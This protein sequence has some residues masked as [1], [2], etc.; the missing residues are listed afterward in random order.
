MF[1]QLANK[2]QIIGANTNT[3]VFAVSQWDR[4][5]YPYALAHTGYISDSHREACYELIVDSNKNDHE[6]ANETVIEKAV[7]HNVDYVIPKDYVGR[8]YETHESFCNYLDLYRDTPECTAQTYAVLQPPYEN[9]YE[10]YEHFY[11][12]F[13][14]FALGGLQT[15]PDAEMQVKEIKRFRETAHNDINVHGFGVG[16]NTEIVKACREAEPFLDSLDIGTPEL[17]VKND[18][19]VDAHMKQF[20]FTIPKGDESTTIRSAFAESILYLLN[21]VLSP[22]PDDEFIEEVYGHESLE[23]ALTDQGDLRDFDGLGTGQNTSA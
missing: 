14:H 3:R 10:E 22:L 19:I 2:M 12:Q 15:L 20:D 21:Y 11:S 1:Q 23:E 16:T 18:A 13:N 9:V 5:F 8:P 4:Y 17:A 7:E 6:V